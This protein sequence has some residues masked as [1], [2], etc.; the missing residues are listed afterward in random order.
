VCI[1]ECVTF[2]IDFFGRKKKKKYEELGNGTVMLNVLLEFSHGI[3]SYVRPRYFT[4]RE[5]KQ[6]PSRNFRM[7]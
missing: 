7:T 1:W 5:F 2:L 6:G 3:A 4:D